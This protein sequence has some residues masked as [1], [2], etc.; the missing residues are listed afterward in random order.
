MNCRCGTGEAMTLLLGTQ[1][2]SLYL[3]PVCQRLAVAVLDGVN[4][5]VS[6]YLPDAVGT[7]P[8]ESP[9]DEGQNET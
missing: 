3:C 8:Y 4:Y 7:R 2:F 6:W 5:Q 9:P 1:H